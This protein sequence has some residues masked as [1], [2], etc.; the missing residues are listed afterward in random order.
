MQTACT[1]I[2]AFI[3]RIFQTTDWKIH[4]HLCG[5][6][7]NT[8][9]DS[10][11][12]LGLAK[13]LVKN[14]T[15]TVDMRS[16]KKIVLRQRQDA[17]ANLVKKLKMML[18]REFKQYNSNTTVSDAASDPAFLAALAEFFSQQKGYELWKE[19][20]VGYKEQLEMDKVV[21]REL[22][23][24]T[25]PDSVIRDVCQGIARNTQT[26]IGLTLADG[27]T[28][29]MLDLERHKRLVDGLVAHTKEF[30]SEHMEYDSYAGL[31]ELGGNADYLAGTGVVISKWAGADEE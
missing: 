2:S 20:S 16:E 3:S 29:E 18:T 5:G 11:T 15:A 30:I 14:H 7:N 26:H 24:L 21:K 31:K 19:L 22:K 6:K 17:T 27:N 8:N 13:L 9:L 4:K 1:N 12:L 10:D 28:S 25:V 23:C